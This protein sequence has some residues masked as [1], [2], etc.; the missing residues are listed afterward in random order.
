MTRPVLRVSVNAGPESAAYYAA[1]SLDDGD[2]DAVANAH[3][4]KAC[5]S[6]AYMQT[7]IHAVQIHG[8]IGFTWDNDTHL[9]FK[10]AK[11]SPTRRSARPRSGG[12]IWVL[13][14]LPANSRPRWRG[15]TGV[16]RGISPFEAVL[17]VI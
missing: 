4:A 6:D 13:N 5:A 8:D 10:R 9:W 3:L 2:N 15:R 17:S 12:S 7:A 16:G 1:A 11:S 14:P